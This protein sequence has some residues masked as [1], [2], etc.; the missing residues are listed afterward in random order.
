MER[1]RGAPGSDACPKRRAFDAL[2]PRWNSLS[3]DA[4]AAA[5]MERGLALL[6][7]L[8][9]ARV[10]DLGCGTGRLEGVLLPR[11]GDG[12]VVAVDF[13]PAM[14]GEASRRLDDPRVTW[15]CRDVHATGIAPRSADVVLCFDA[16]P[17]FHGPAALLAEVARWLRPTG[18]FLL[19]HDIGREALASVHRRAGPAVEDD[20][21]PPVREL[22]ELAAGAGLSV[23]LAVEDDASYTLLT[24]R[25]A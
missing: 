6:G 24:R 10:V 18:A 13:S 4:A 7:D 15:L 5:G 21:L 19:W 12:S 25:P 1:E 20:L 22:A 3:R 11:L 23:E 2:A 14:L 9:G 8:T 16:F 17:H